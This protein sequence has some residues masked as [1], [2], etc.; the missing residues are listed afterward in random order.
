MKGLL[1]VLTP[2]STLI[3]HTRAR[4]HTHTS[5]HPHSR[6]CPNERCRPSA[7]GPAESKREGLCPP[8]HDTVCPCV[9]PTWTKVLF[10][11]MTLTW[12]LHD[13]KWSIWILLFKRLLFTLADSLILINF[14]FNL[15]EKWQPMEGRKEKTTHH[16]GLCLYV[17]DWFFIQTVFCKCDFE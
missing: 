16:R 13:T 12:H 14:T 2:S 17:L 4:V 7:Q 15:E 5:T 10:W 1:L 11:K 6:V 3:S 9:W 8:Q